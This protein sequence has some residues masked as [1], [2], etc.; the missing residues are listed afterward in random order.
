MQQTELYL[1]LVSE[2]YFFMA[3][4]TFIQT[5]TSPPAPV[6]ISGALS[7]VRVLETEL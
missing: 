6:Y 2:N 5:T 4:L 7:A 3:M 1:D